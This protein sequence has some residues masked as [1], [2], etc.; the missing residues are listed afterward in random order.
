MSLSGEDKV[1]DL[2]LQELFS[3]KHRVLFHQTFIVSPII[4]LVTN[5]NMFWVKYITIK[6]RNR[7]FTD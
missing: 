3:V 1:S 4:T 7:A 2:S 5:L 6:L